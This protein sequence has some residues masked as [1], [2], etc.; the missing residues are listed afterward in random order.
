MTQANSDI[1]WFDQI[2]KNDVPL[3][4]GKGANLGE[5]T[6]AGIPVPG[7]FVVATSA[8]RRFMEQAGLDATLRE[9]LGSLDVSDTAK[10]TAISDELRRS[11]LTAS[12]PDDITSAITESYT[13]LGGGLVAVRSSG[14]SSSA[15]G[16]SPVSSTMVR[17]SPPGPGWPAEI[18]K[19]GTSFNPIHALRSGHQWPPQSG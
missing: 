6:Q 17:T 9:L 12:M 11:M 10:L 5:M 14:F 8:Y 2:S 4:G 19:N 1:V 18:V 13:S 15:A 3:V 7:G 16:A